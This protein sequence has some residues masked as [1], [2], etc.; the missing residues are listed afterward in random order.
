MTK[1]QMIAAAPLAVLLVVSVV[2]AGISLFQVVT[3]SWQGAALVIFTAWAVV[4][5]L[6]LMANRDS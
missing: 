6:Y 2:G 1:W 4:G 5:F 3:A